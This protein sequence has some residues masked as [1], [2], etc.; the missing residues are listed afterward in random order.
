MFLYHYSWIWSILLK[1]AWKCAPPGT[2]GRHFWS[3]TTLFPAEPLAVSESFSLWKA[4]PVDLSDMLMKLVCQGLRSSL[5]AFILCH[6]CGLLLQFL[7]QVFSAHFN[8]ILLKYKIC[9]CCYFW[10]PLCSNWSSF[11]VRARTSHFVSHQVQCLA[12]CGCSASLTIVTDH[13]HGVRGWS[14]WWG[15]HAGLMI[16]ARTGLV[17]PLSPSGVCRRPCS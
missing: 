2:R 1:Q 12:H 4:L 17:P 14:A 7:V 5:L 9:L 3:N 13:L 6:S 15:L 8:L 11:K 10:S 16:V